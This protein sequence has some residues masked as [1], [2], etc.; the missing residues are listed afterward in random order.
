MNLNTFLNQLAGEPSRNAKIAML[1]ANKSNE[2]LREVVRLALDPFTQFYQRKIPVYKTS[3]TVTSLENAL[4][5]LYTLSSRTVTGNAAI[6][7]LR[8]LLS[9]V[10]AD[11]A[12]VLE[13]IIDKSLDCGVNSSTANKVWM[14]LIKEYPVMLCSP[15]EQRLVDKIKFPAYVQL[16]MDGMRFNAI[17]RDGKCEF[18]SRNGKEIQ[19]LGNLEQ[20]FINLAGD[21]DCVFD[22]ELLV[23]MPGDDQFVDRQTGNGI[24]NKANKG[25]ISAEQ[26]ALVHATVWDVIPYV[27]FSDSYCA[28]PYSTRFSSLKKLID[29]IPARDKKI[30]LVSSDIVENIDQANAKFEEYLGLGLEGI[31]LKDGSGPWEDKRAKHQIKFK[32][33]L[34]C[35]LKIVAVE[36]GTGKYEGMLGAIVCESADG[37]VK[38]NVGSGFNDEHRKTLKEK[39]LL[40]KIVAVKYNTRIQNKSGAESLFLPIFVEVREDKT[41]ADNSKD[42]K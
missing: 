34:E 6:E 9:S 8:M 42:I 30:W 15:F 11:D 16:K 25:T 18:R 39:D 33:E 1:E 20:E 17:V 14:G 13:R 38:V 41:D 29:E 40:G 2:L 26:A 31:I 7:Y 36:E 19:L 24:L 28:T 4:H 27:L 32:G 21:I 3:D 10:S 12:K 23:M 37:V 5:A 35:D 22:G